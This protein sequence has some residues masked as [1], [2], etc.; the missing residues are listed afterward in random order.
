MLEYGQLHCIVAKV[1]N[2]SSG[3]VLNSPVVAMSLP[4]LPEGSPLNT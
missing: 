4:I 1:I 2:E 3:S